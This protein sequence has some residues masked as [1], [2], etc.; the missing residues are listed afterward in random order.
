[1]LSGFVAKESVVGTLGILYGVTG[2]VIENGN[3]LYA[4]I[5]AHFTALQAYS[6]MTFALLATPCVAAVAAM[7]RELAS[8]K[9]FT[10]IL[11][12]ELAVAYLASLLIFQI[13]S[14][15]I[16]G[17]F[18]LIFGVLVIIFV[19]SMIVKVV[20]R[21]GVTCSHCDGCSSISSCHLPQREKYY[22]DK[23]NQNDSEK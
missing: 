6:F 13:G 14:M 8:W 21:K 20:R 16:G 15:G 11:V 2:N 7:K 4:D 5:Q 12:Y 23:E 17:A 22:S 9:W 18:S 10:F 1:M 19:V 3:L